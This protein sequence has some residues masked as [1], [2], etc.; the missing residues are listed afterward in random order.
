VFCR[1]KTI[2]LI[3]RLRQAF[4]RKEVKEFKKILEDPD[5][6]IKKVEVYIDF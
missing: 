5:A 6:K 3:M 2:N 1:N 4:D